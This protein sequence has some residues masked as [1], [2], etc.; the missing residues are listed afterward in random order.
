MELFLLKTKIFKQIFRG[1]KNEILIL[2]SIDNASFH[3]STLWNLFLY[4]YLK[5]VSYR[6][7][8]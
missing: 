6:T 7:H 1:F 4:H 8:L 2:E 5:K 3:K